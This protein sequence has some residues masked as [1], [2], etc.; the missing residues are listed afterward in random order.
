MKIAEIAKIPALLLMA[1]LLLSCE[2]FLGPEP[3]TSPQG[4]LKSLW[5]DFNNI[6]AYLDYRMSLNNSYNDWHDV[7]HNKTNGFALRV[8][9]NM[10]EQSLFSVCENM[11]KQLNDPHVALYKPGDIGYSYSAGNQASGSKFFPDDVKKLLENG[12][13]TQYSNFI[14]GVFTPVYAEPRIGYIYI[15]DF[16]EGKEDAAYEN[17]GKAIDSIIKE[18]SNTKAIVLDIRSNRG[19]HV[20]VMEYIAARFASSKKEYIKVKMKNGPGANNYGSP[21]TH[22]IIPSNLNY[23]KPVVLLTNNDSVSAA[24]RF[25]IAL[26]TQN[27]VTHAGTAT[28]GA[29]SVRVERAM[30]NGWFYSISPEMVTDMNGKIYEGIGVIPDAQHIIESGADDAQTKKAK[31]LAVSLCK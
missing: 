12:G 28:R 15:Y 27:H 9:N 4:I 16:L 10:S 6:Y 7:Y 5:S 3:D 31:E 30:I 29:L 23:T 20:Y 8:R 2:L 14:Y 13:K 26:R 24:E 22:I 25:T 19:G 17:W 18:L 1:A 11:L 21:K